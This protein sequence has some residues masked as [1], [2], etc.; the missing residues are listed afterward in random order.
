MHFATNDRELMDVTGRHTD[1]DTRDD[2][3]AVVASDTLQDDPFDDDLAER[4]TAL[5][6]RPVPRTT[7]ALV[8]LVVLVSGFVGG[9]L[10]QKSYGQAPA[11]AANN[12]PANLP[13]GGFQ[14]QPGQG[15]GNQAGSAT[16]GTIKL[17]DG[18]TV[19]LTLANG[20][21]AT[22]KTSDQTAVQQPAALTDLKV[23]QSVT[24]QGSAGTDGII[25]A[26][27]VTAEK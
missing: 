8:G 4:V 10:V 14:G 20:D 6:P 27:S 15:R 19:Y 21:I 3:P 17:I 26:T 13:A 11:A 22:V 7:L 24:V 5:A 23:G 25:T 12:F 18:T 9:V 2:L 16:T 1:G